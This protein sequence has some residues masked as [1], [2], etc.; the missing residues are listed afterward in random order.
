LSKKKKEPEAKRGT[1]GRK[2]RK[3]KEGTLPK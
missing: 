1:A 3:K 2:E